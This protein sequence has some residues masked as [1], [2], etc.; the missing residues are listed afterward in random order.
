MLLYNNNYINYNYII[1]EKDEKDGED[2]EIELISAGDGS[3]SLVKGLL[4]PPTSFSL[5]H[6]VQLSRPYCVHHCEGKTY[7][8][9]YV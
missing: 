5:P 7:V 8:G 9:G 3:I 1:T 2:V 4:F 6:N